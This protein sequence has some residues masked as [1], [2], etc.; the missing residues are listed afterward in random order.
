MICEVV[1]GDGDKRGAAGAID[2]A[3]RRICQVTVIHPHIG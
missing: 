1:V 3:I 2:Q